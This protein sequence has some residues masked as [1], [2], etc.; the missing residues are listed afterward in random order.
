MTTDPGKRA[1]GSSEL[2]LSTDA[3]WRSLS[4]ENFRGFYRRADFDLAANAILVH[5]PNGTGKTSFFDAIQWLLLGD[6]ERLKVLRLRRT[7][8]YI[9][10][11]YGKGPAR[12]SAD[13]VLDGRLVRLERHG[14][15][16]GSE[17]S[18][19]A[20]GEGLLVGHA[21]QERLDA[22]LNPS[23]TMALKELLFSS[24][25]MQ[26][27]DL[28]YVLHSSPS[29][30]FEQ[31]SHLLG[32]GALEAFE[33]EVI[34]S[35]KASQELARAAR[36]G[37]A[38]ART[39]VEKAH[40]EVQQAETDESALPAA[41]A[42]LD[43]LA[44]ELMALTAK[45]PVRVSLPALPGEVESLRMEL[46]IAHAQLDDILALSARV[47]GSR[48]ELDESERIA[49]AMQGDAMQS[50]ASARSLVEE[51]E[52]VLSTL[53]SLEEKARAELDAFA[54]FVVHA[55]PLLSDE[56][57]VCRRPIDRSDMATDLRQRAAGS[58]QLE[59]IRAQIQ[60]QAQE[61][62]SAA[63][64]Y[65]VAAA[66]LRNA[67][68][69]MAAATEARAALDRIDDAIAKL[70]RLARVSIQENEGYLGNP[71][72]RHRTE[73]IRDTIST[74][75]RAVDWATGA[76]S[77]VSRTSRLPQVRE[78]LE[79]AIQRE[80]SVRKRWEA[81]AAA[82]SKD[83]TLAK[84]SARARLQVIE[85]RLAALQPLADD[86]FNRLNPHPTFRRF[87]Y[88]SEML[89]NKGTITARAEDEERG[90]VVSPALAFSSA[91][92][93]M[94]SLTYF[95][96]LAWS[97]GNRSL[98]FVCLDDPLQEMDDVNVLAFADLARHLRE[99]R[100][101]FIATHERRF[102]G[103]LRRKLAP[104][105][106]RDSIVIIEFNGWSYEGPDYQ[107]ERVSHTESERPL[108]LLA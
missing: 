92:A 52:A 88:D 103:L 41:S 64:R 25:L 37:A 78:R 85:R 31:V 12:V 23:S 32:L 51:K 99:D 83:D 45:H 84:A 107:Q 106:K 13:L 81:L 62:S 67:E 69:Q 15:R 71:A 10:N 68:G 3:C 14:D 94:T 77:A 35:A 58:G 11:A 82:A 21:A 18:M 50:L 22:I 2:A 4:I 63:E 95:L 59:S 86:I 26:Q 76:L 48:Q 108:R 29:D 17:L 49:A 5:G 16:S 65:D 46:S 55:I 33:D 56:C 20:D 42:I 7:D 1:E 105:A 74:V 79:I 93:N 100:Q 8:E 27:D 73:Q 6:I 24:A 98:P 39:D 87:R 40:A 97:M 91:Q 54:Q 34:R 61:R 60:E 70:Q 101:L 102:A 43:S 53:R 89:R 44:N 75:L 96:A 72:F 104:R 30:R 38:L 28:R 80:A 90:V 9:A 66:Q 47:T 57:P 19:E 36:E